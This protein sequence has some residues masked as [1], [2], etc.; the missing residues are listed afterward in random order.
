MPDLAQLG[1]N[2]ELKSQLENDQVD[3]NDVA[4]V[5]KE[6][7]ELYVIQNSLGIFNAEITGKMRFDASSRADYPAVGDWVGV[8]IFEGDQAIIHQIYPRFSTLERQSVD[9]HGEKQLIATNVNAAFIVQSVD[10]DFN[11][12]RLERYFVLAHNG[13]IKPIVILNKIDFIADDKK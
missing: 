7:R 10:R 8:S 9:A 4:R 5:I 3:F 11:V 6:H 2:S 13:G 12:N 1:L